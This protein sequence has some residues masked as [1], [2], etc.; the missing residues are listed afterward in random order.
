[1]C[2]CNLFAIE[3]KKHFMYANEVKTM[4]GQNKRVQPKYMYRNPPLDILVLE[5][6]DIRVNSVPTG[7]KQQSLESRAVGLPHR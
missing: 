3:N 1:M 4:G 6:F 2:P 7:S 5:H